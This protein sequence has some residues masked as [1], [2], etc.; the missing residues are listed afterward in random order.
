MAKF[1]SGVQYEN[2]VCAQVFFTDQ[3]ALTN[4]L[5]IG[6]QLVQ[7]RSSSDGNTPENQPKHRSQADQDAWMVHT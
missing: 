6:A 1:T 5:A 3:P 7:F 4:Y 2:G